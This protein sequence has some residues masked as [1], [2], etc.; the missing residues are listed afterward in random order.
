[1][2]YQLFVDNIEPVER[3][4]HEADVVDWLTRTAEQ[5]LLEAT[6]VH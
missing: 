3:R 1:M 5:T 4:H 2:I 6:A